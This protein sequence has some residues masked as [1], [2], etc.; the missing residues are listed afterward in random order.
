VHA[1]R[2]ILI[3]EEPVAD[4]PH[5]TKK[6][7]VG[8][9]PSSSAAVQSP[10]AALGRSTELKKATGQWLYAYATTE[11]SSFSLDLR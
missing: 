2:S 4:R 6:G 8:E 1:T 7:G 5:K 10:L 3:G 11:L 9:I